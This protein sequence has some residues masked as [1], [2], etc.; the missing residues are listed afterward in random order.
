VAPLRLLDRHFAVSGILHAYAFDLR[1]ELLEL[2][3]KDERAREPS[4]LSAQFTGAGM[5]LL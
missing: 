1:R 3:G 5:Q 2:G 4:C